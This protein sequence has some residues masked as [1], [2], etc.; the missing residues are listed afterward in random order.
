MNMKLLNLLICAIPLLT[1]IL[2]STQVRSK[3]ITCD[4]DFKYDNDTNNQVKPWQ[5]CTKM[6]LTKDTKATVEAYGYSM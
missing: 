4:V 2:L 3:V 1:S 5:F 6:S